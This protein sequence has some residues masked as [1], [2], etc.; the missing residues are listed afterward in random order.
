MARRGKHGSA[1]K[2]GDHVLVGT[3]RLLPSDWFL[4]RVLWADAADALTEHQGV[5]HRIR[6]AV[7]LDEVVAW[8]SLDELRR[9]QA[10]A[11]KAV[12]ALRGD[13]RQAEELLGRARSAVADRLEALW[14]RAD[15]PTSAA[16]AAP[17]PEFSL[18][19]PGL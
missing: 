10:E 3:P 4:A 9:F 17:Q 16:A 18:T 13:V 2:V 15:E 1:P 14:A 11:T 5:T 7:S 6:Q 8:G 19:A 12:E